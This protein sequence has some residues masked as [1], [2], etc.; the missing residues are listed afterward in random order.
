MFE[1]GND[2]RVALYKHFFSSN[3]SEDDTKLN[4]HDFMER[5]KELSNIISEN[6]EKNIKISYFL[7][8]PLIFGLSYHILEIISEITKDGFCYCCKF[9]NF[10]PTFNDKV[11]LVLLDLNSYDYF[12]DIAKKYDGTINLRLFARLRKAYI[13]ENFNLYLHHDKK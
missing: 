13:S 9:D 1:F 8:D 11:L 7:L 2:T 3:S 4:D 12:K 5:V 10:Y 6:Y